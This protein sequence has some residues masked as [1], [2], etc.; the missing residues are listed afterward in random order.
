MPTWPATNALA[1]NVTENAMWKR[2]VTLMIS[3]KPMATSAYS[4]PLDN[5]CRQVLQQVG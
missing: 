1:A 2:P 3:A 5:A 4:E